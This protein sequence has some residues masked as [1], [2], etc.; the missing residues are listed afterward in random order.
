MHLQAI[1]IP[2]CDTVNQFQHHTD[3]KDCAQNTLCAV[4]SFTHALFDTDSE[5][6]WILSSHWSQAIDSCPIPCLL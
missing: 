5:L 2:H 6:R 4:V 1:P 3:I